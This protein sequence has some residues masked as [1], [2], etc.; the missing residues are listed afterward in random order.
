MGIAQSV[1]IVMLWASSGTIAPPR[2]MIN[3]SLTNLP[4]SSF[5][6]SGSPLNFYSSSS[7]PKDSPAHLTPCRLNLQPS[8]SYL[9][10][11]RLRL[12]RSSISLNDR[13]LNQKDLSWM[14]DRSPINFGIVVIR[15]QTRTTENC[16]PLI[17]SAKTRVIRTVDSCHFYHS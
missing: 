8:P 4:T 12:D 7:M 15:S 2:L 9:N 3:H 6:F 1:S 10:S 5:M 13:G 11:S 17:I 14:L 16:C